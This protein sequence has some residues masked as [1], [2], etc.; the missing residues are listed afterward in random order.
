ML[1]QDLIVTPI[2]FPDPPLLNAAGAHEPLALRSVV[3]L[4]VTGGVVGLGEGWGEQEVVERLRGVRDEI[5]GLSVFDLASVECAVDRVFLPGDDEAFIRRAVF[6]VIEVACHDAQGKVLDVPVSTLL[7]GSVRDRVDFSGYLFYKWDR[8]PNTDSPADRWG[9]ALDPAGIVRQAQM[10][11]DEFGFRSLKLKGGVFPPGEEAVA[12]EALADAFPGLPLRIDPNG[13]WSIDTALVIA[14]RLRGKLEYL[15]DPT[16][17]MSGMADVARDAGIPL[18]TNM[19]V[20]GFEHIPDAVSSGAVQI[21]LSDHHF[22]GGL[23]RTRELGV[24]CKTFGLGLSMHSNSHLGISLAAMTH[25]AAA[26]PRIDYACDTH[27]PWNAAYDV[28]KPGALEIRDG[29]VRTPTG[30]G[31]GIE[32]DEA[33]LGDLH[34]L[35]VQSGRTHRNDARYMRTVHPEFADVRPRY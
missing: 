4:V 1:I 23:R 17:G 34:A 27:Y 6:S 26:M 28:I 15:E 16:M 19:C 24:I 29:A 8:H 2:A 10:M 33:R 25:V 5:I 22:W 11:I 35:Y 20:V 31:L 12:V 32:L 7:G 9:E 18:A 30:P 13:A 14:E 3:Q 21:I